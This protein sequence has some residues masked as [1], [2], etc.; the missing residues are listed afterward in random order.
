M[1]PN[2]PPPYCQTDTLSLFNTRFKRAPSSHP[3]MDTHPLILHPSQPSSPGWTMIFFVPFGKMSFLLV[4]CSLS[5]TSPWCSDWVTMETTRMRSLV[6]LLINFTTSHCFVCL[7]YISFIRKIRSPLRSPCN[8]AK[9][10]LETSPH[11]YVTPLLKS[12]LNPEAKI[13]A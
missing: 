6:S 4:L 7:Q 8:S 5:F 11:S 10:P 2:N 1:D 13:R 3:Q 9:D 12:T